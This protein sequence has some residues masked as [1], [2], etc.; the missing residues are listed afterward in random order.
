MRLDIYLVKTKLFESRN[1]AQEAIKS[2]LVRVDGKRV[3]KAATDICEGAVVELEETKYYI[4]RAARKLEAYLES[5]PLEVEGRRALDIG[6]STGG[7]TQI[8]L[9]RGVKFVDAVDVGREQLHPSLRREKRVN[10]F[11]ETDIRNFDRGVLYELIVSD[12]SLISLR[13]IIP[14]IERLSAKECDMILLFKPQFEVGPAAK[15]DS[16]GVVKDLDAIE[17][18]KR[19]FEEDAQIRGWRLLRCVQSAITGKDGNVE[20]IYHFC[21][22]RS[23]ESAEDD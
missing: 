8:L 12:I 11:E 22:S 17:S 15:R 16:R 5:H 18:A 19:V 23:E 13:Y 9:E 14:S 20:Y 2:G 7:F 4:S 21:K 10:S 3:K 1:R 6:S